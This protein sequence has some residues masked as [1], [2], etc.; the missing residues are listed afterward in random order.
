MSAERQTPPP[1]LVI[2]ALVV[3]PVLV[4]FGALDNEFHLDDLYRVDGN[5]EVE[6]LHPMGRHFVDAGTSSSLTRLHQ[7]RP[8]LPLTLSINH[9]IAGHSLIGYH[10][11]NL[12]A[13]IISVLLLYRLVRE[14]TAG[15]TGLGS[16]W[17]AGGAALLWGVHPVSGVPINYI[18]ARDL[19]LM[20]TFLLGSLLVYVRMRRRGDS[21]LGWAATLLLMALS[22]LSKTNA[23]A[24]PLVVLAYEMC[25]GTGR[26][27]A[28]ATWKRVL[29]FAAVSA[30]FFAWTRLGLGFSD[31]ESLKTERESLEY[32]LTQLSVHVGHYLR[33]VVWP[34]EMRPLPYIELVTSPTDTMALIGAAVVLGSLYLA[35][36]LRHAAPVASFG[37][38]AYWLMFAP[39]SSVLPFRYLATDYRAYS[40]LAF[41]FVVG[42]VL[43]AR[44]GRIAGALAVALL[45]WFGWASHLQNGVWQDE[46]SLWSQSVKYG[47]E[48]TA[49]LNLGRAYRGVDDVLAREHLEKAIE[50]EPT[51]VLAFINLGLLDIAEGHAETGLARVKRAT[52]FRPE[53]PDAWHWYA[54][55]LQDVGKFGEGAD[56]SVHALKLDPSNIELMYFA[57]FHLM[58]ADRFAESLGIV[59]RLLKLRPD[60]LDS[61]FIRAWNLHNLNRLQEAVDEYRLY[62]QDHEDV[63]AEKN[64]EIALE[65]LAG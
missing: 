54:R 9:A 4:F 7:Y 30:G 10:L 27:F 14:L 40:S 16:P 2:A 56:T 64:L 24:L 62:L 6:Q 49:H 1:F 60:Y 39:T 61:R 3:L 13:H 15:P 11:G 35:W 8:M 38:L 42:G 36:R 43:F 34:F 17:L 29:P 65:K 51:F 32:A 58:R 31:L 22:C 25:L 46:I 48:E 5:P 28:L 63:Q 52:E 21:A 18:C 59:D 26:P 45:G 57:A 41:L 53:W 44:S 23:V 12:L 50:L 19:A 47:A 20:Q 37:I 55:A 33:N